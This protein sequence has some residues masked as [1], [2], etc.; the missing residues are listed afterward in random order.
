MSICLCL[1][2]GKRIV[3]YIENNGGKRILKYSNLIEVLPSALNHT[4]KESYRTF[5]VGFSG[6]EAS[7]YLASSPF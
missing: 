5:R 1:G 6:D 2:K 3:I 7:F 4:K